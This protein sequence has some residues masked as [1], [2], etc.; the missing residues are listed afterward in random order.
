[1]KRNNYKIK[2]KTD[3]GLRV[4]GGMCYGGKHAGGWRHGEGG[5]E[6]ERGGENCLRRR[7]ALA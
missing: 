4:E 3:W 6:P 7:F 1:M 5:G 2:D